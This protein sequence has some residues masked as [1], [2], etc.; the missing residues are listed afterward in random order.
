[1][2]ELTI[3]TLQ[4]SNLYTRIKEIAIFETDILVES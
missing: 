3:L 1:M 2:L 4:I